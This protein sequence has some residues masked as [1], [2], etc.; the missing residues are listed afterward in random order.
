LPELSTYRGSC[1]TLKSGLLDLF[2]EKSKDIK[3]VNPQV[4]PF[5]VFMAFRKKDPKDRFL[6]FCNS[7]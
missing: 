1:K 4:L 7:L 2:C 3:T 5:Y 6:E